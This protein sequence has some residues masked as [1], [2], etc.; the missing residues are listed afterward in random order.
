MSQ[1]PRLY[2]ISDLHLSAAHPK[3]MDIFGPGWRDH[4][5]RIREN[6]R[7]TVADDDIVLIAGDISWAM[8]LDE[9]AA[10]LAW[11]SA[12]PGRKVMI[13]GNHDYWWQSIG[14]VRKAMKPGMHCLQNNALEIDG[15]AFAGT[16]LWDFPGITW[17]PDPAQAGMRQP[18]RAAQE[19]TGAPRNSD[20]EKIRKR[21]IERLRLSLSRLPQDADQRIVLT[22]F[23]PLGDNGKPSHITD[24]ISE[25]HVDLCVFGHLHA[26]GSIPRPGADCRIGKTRYV[27]TSC[28]WLECGLMDVTIMNDE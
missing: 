14:R 28:D 16:R 25:F 5:S 12:L 1:M 22:H 27:L 11:I 13:R 4:V 21:E 20:P 24:I 7:K 19:R 26:L 9:A 10:D 15:F 18:G 8:R 2:A 17:Q 3:P 23:P 6:W